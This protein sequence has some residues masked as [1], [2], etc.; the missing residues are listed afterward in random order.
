[1]SAGKIM[2]P[3]AAIAGRAAALG[4]LSS[5]ETSS[6]LISRPTTKKKMTM[7]ASLTTS[8]IDSSRWK[9]P[10][11]N[12]TWVLQNRSY[13]SPNGAFAQT[14]AAAAARSRTIPPDDSTR[15]NRSTGRTNRDGIARSD[16]IQVT[17]T[18]ACRE[19]GSI[20][21]GGYSEA[22]AASQQSPAAHESLSN[23]ELRI[24][25]DG[26]SVQGPTP[27]T[28][29]PAEAATSLLHASPPPLRPHEDRHRGGRRRRRLPR[30]AAQ[31]GRPGRR[32]HRSERAPGR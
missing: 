11:L 25:V 9:P 27:R 14:N 21:G 30:R 2:P 6:R 8:R 13:V 17:W 1:M 23:C 10:T 3:S 18:R 7:R 26:Q 31:R 29:G 22:T 19:G 24:A 12:A 15:V 20:G 16:E 5:P 28:A 4:S 32:G